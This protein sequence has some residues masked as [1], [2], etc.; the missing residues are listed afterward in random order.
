[1]SRKSVAFTPILA[2][3][4]LAGCDVIHRGQVRAPTTLED[5]YLTSFQSDADVE[6]PVVVL[7]KNPGNNE[8][9]AVTKCAAAVIQSAIDECIYLTLTNDRLAR[10]DNWKTILL[11][12]SAAAGPL[13]LA[14][15][16]STTAVA[17][18]SSS[19]TA[20]AILGSSLFGTIATPPQSSVSNMVTA[21]SAYVLLSPHPVPPDEG[22]K[23]HPPL[24]GPV[25]SPNF[26]S[27]DRNYRKLYDAALS[28]CDPSVAN[29]P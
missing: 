23:T 14:F 15:G 16:G 27:N 8:S 26:A 12:S 22:K 20:G 19:S 3:L 7:S 10:S 6:I 13:A 9:V 17:V 18:V 25:D 2:L 28:Q 24:Y 4:L 21:A 1:M 5:T 29:G 11:I